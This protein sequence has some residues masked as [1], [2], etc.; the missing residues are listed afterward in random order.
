MK[1]FHYLVLVNSLFFV[2]VFFSNSKLLFTFLSIKTFTV[3]SKLRFM[4]SVEIQAKWYFS[5]WDLINIWGFKI[6]KNDDVFV[7]LFNVKKCL[8]TKKKLTS[9]PV[10]QWVPSFL[11]YMQFLLHPLF[12]I[13]TPL[14]FL[15]FFLHFSLL[16]LLLLFIYFCHFFFF[17]SFKHI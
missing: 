1:L 9:S 2:L 12:Q 3:K 8:G 6:L 5:L 13:C 4:I 17:L 10:D 16:F 14:L 7:L 15:S 11:S